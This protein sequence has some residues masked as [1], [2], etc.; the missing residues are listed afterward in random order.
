MR[1][2]RNGDDYHDGD[3]TLV[4]VFAMDRTA[5]LTSDTGERYVANLSLQTLIQEMEVLCRTL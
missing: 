2:C 5:W 4:F 1:V 3:R